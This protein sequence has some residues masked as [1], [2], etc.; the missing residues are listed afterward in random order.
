MVGIVDSPTP[1]VPIS[2]DSTKVTSSRSRNWWVSAHAVTQPAV[3]PPAITTLRIRFL[4][5]TLPSV[6]KAAAPVA[7]GC[8][9]PWRRIRGPARSAVEFGYQGRAHPARG[10]FIEWCQLAARLF[11][12]VLAGACGRAEHV[13]LEQLAPGALLL[14]RAVADRPHRQAERVHRRGDPGRHA[15]PPVVD[16]HGERI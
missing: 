15:A 2:S 3:P 10:G 8:A 13:V 16:Q 6:A 7:C 11:G 1:T 9:R 14:L 5:K 12:Q 4:S